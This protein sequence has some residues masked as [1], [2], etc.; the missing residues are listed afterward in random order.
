[1][2]LKASQFL[3]SR[4]CHDLIGPA[5]A[6]N[7][8]MEL[9]S[10]GDVSDDEALSLVAGSVTQ[11]IRRLE[12]FRVAFGRGGGTGS[13]A[14]SEARRLAVNLM[15]DGKVALDWADEETGTV[16]G[17][18]CNGGVKL[19]MNLVLLALDSLPRG[20]TIAV[21]M[22]DLSNGVGVAVIGSGIGAGLKDGISSVMS[23][24]VSGDAMSAHTVAAY[25]AQQLAASLGQRIEISDEEDGEVRF[26]ALL[27][28]EKIDD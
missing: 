10:D 13:R 3:C 9:L 16:D 11:V 21:R 1:M 5:G 22:A 2:D 19:V 27:P 20:G 26:A 4:I 14:L 17:K 15:A 25:F 24:D 6:V 12:Y 23:Q 7:T 8:G 28:R 18:V